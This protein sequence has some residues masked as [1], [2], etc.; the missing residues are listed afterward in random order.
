MKKYILIMVFPFLL[1]GCTT[2]TYVKLPEDSVLKIKR[3]K[4][5][6]I[7]EGRVV[8]SPFS[9]SSAGGIPYK[10]EKNG[11]VLSQGVMRAKF[12]PAAIFWPPFALFYWPIGF[13]QNCYDLTGEAAKE[14]TVEMLKELRS[15]NQ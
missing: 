15:K 2:S 1:L 3:G 7:Q 5:V 9:W 8:R 4:E 10:V 11:E 12:R 14:C 13:R 6:P